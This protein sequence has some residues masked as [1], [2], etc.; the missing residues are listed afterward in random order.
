MRRRQFITLLGGTRQ[1]M[2]PLRSYCSTCSTAGGAF[3][4]E[5]AELIRAQSIA[6]RERG[7]VGAHQGLVTSDGLL[8]ARARRSRST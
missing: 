3:A 5:L 2:L 1:S 4:E 6:V 7:P 8:T